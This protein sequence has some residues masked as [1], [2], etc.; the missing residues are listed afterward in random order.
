MPSG[1]TRCW[2]RSDRAGARR[3]DQRSPRPARPDSAS[4]NGYP[5]VASPGV[6][7]S[8]PDSG[9]GNALASE[10]WPAHPCRRGPPPEAAPRPS[11]QPCRA[12]TPTPPRHERRATEWDRITRPGV[13]TNAPPGSPPQACQ[14]TRPG[15]GKPSSPRRNPDA[16]L[17]TTCRAKY[18]RILRT[19]SSLTSCPSASYWARRRPTSVK[20]RPAL[21]SAIQRRARWAACWTPLGGRCPIRGSFDRVA[22]DVRTR[23]AP[24]SSPG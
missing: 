12:G 18:A 22:P 2:A 10:T 20:L 7:G 24:G 17:S 23:E 6:I 16:S 9:R 5:A 19:T 4:S 13:W 21:P 8:P 3:W 11:C 15:E 14:A 1:T